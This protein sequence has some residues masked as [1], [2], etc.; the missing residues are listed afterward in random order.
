MQ[1]QRVFPL[2]VGE[3]DGF[4]RLRAAALRQRRA[5]KTSASIKLMTNTLV[6]SLIHLQ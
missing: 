4:R 3:D 2:P 1:A 6:F 5:V